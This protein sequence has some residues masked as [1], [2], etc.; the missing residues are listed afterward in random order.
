M[1]KLSPLDSR[2]STI[3]AIPADGRRLD[4]LCAGIIVADHVCRPIAA[5]PP[6]GGLVLTPG[7]ELTVGGCA[8]NVAVDLAQLGRRVAVAGCVGDDAF[9]RHVADHLRGAGIDCADV[10]VSDRRE[11]AC[12][13]VVNVAGEDRRFIHA[14][15]ANAEF[16]GG[17]LSGGRIA[18]ARVLYVGGYGL[19]E[20]LS[21]RNVVRL[22]Q[23]A[24][25]QGAATVLDV[26]L[27]EP[28]DFSE[29]FGCVLPLTDVFLPN[30]DEARLLTGIDDPLQ[31]AETFCAAGAKTAVVTAGE[32]G[33]VLVSGK[34]RLRAA[35]HRVEAIDG[36]GSGD[37]FLAGFLH[38]LLDGRDLAAA[39][40]SGAAL[41]ACCVR[42]A[43][44]TTGIPT[45]GELQAMVDSQP[46]AVEET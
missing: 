8:A 19:V 10:R 13:M 31:Q 44:A 28:R 17:D 37:A 40:R 14:L 43:G 20:S 16:T 34:T 35:A 21:P 30:S 11:T 15:G 46:L 32:A 26:V 42:H 7:M 38:A 24:S 39:L 12:T 45:A 36:T 2:L 29:W 41:G 23:E 3:P 33:A 18:Q 22:F 5:M 25:R 4:V 27:A 9:G 6:P 1:A